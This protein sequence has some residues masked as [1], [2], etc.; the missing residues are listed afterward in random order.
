[1][2]VDATTENF[3]EEHTVKTSKINKEVNQE[4]ENLKLLTV[5]KL[6]NKFLF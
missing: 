3:E 1:M 4:F 2:L 5:I 6:K